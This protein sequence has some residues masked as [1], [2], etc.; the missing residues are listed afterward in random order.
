MKKIILLFVPLFY[1]SL[2][3]SQT[4][5]IGNLPNSNYSGGVTGVWDMNNDGLNDIV[6]MNQSTTL[7]VL[8][9]Q[10]N[11]TFI[12]SQIATGPLST[13]QWG[14][15]VG[16]INN[17]GFGDVLCGGYY[18]GAH[19]YSSDSNG[20]YSVSLSNPPSIFMQACLFGDFDNDGWLD[21]FAC[22]DDGPAFM[23]RNDGSGILIPDQTIIDYNLYPGVYPGTSDPLMSGNYGNEFCDFD[24]DRDMDLLVAKCRQASN[25]PYD[26][27][28]TNLLFV[29]DGNNNYSDDA[30]NRGLVNL[31]QTWTATFGDIDNDGDFDCFMTTHSG[32]LEMYENNGLGYFTNITSGSGLE[33]SGFFMQGQMADF[34]NDGYLDIIHAGGNFGYYHNNGD[35]TFTQMSSLFQNPSTMHGFALG[36]LNNDGFIDVYANYGDPNGYVTPGNNPDRLWLTQPNSNNWIGFDLEGVISNKNAVGTLVEIHGDFGTQI[37]EVRSGVSYGITNSNMLLFGIGASASIDYA[38]IYWPAGGIEV[39]E[40]PGINGYHQIFE[41][42]CSTSA[43]VSIISNGGTTLCQGSSIDLSISTVNSNFIWSN[44]ETTSSINVS[45]SGN[46]FV[47]RVNPI[48]FRSRLKIMKFLQLP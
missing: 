2:V 27:R 33:V 38:V 9:Q 12:E 43:S 17:D 39:V 26:V 24:R 47:V 42:D 36:D 25:D 29:N 34:D 8:Y 10:L 13:S 20:A 18:E 15:T 41:S 7:K 46:Y 37:R 23:W 5:S 14:M 30:H 19:I 6:V 21:A 32:T 1:S 40:N 35:K 11:G 16:D 44:G 4:F 31:Q 28:R 45:T 3:N 48:Q 22:H